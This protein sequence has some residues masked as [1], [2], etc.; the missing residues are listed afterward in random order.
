MLKTDEVLSATKGWWPMDSATWGLSGL[1]L[2]L[3][4]VGWSV[5]AASARIPMVLGPA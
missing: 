3:D 1:Q 2:S 4:H 5:N